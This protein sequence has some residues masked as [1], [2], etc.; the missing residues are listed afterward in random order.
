MVRVI[1][2][3]RGGRSGLAG[4]LVFALALSS[5][6][7]GE[8]TARAAALERE[9]ARLAEPAQGSVGVAAIHLGTGE[10]AYLNRGETFPKIGRASCRERV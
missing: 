5:A 6:A 7:R 1:V 3:L 2:N 8:D 9:F 4:F 10:A